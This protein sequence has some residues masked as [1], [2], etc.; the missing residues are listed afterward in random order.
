LPPSRY[1]RDMRPSHLLTTLY[2]TLS[3]ALFLSS[4]QNLHAQPIAFPDVTING[5]KHPFVIVE[6]LKDQI[7]YTINSHTTTTDFERLPPELQGLIKPKLQVE[8]EEE[9]EE[10]EEAGYN[11]NKNMPQLNKEQLAT[12]AQQHLTQTIK[13][14]LTSPESYSSIS[15]SHYSLNGDVYLKHK[16]RA[17]SPTTGKKRSY[18]VEAKLDSRGN[19]KY[20]NWKNQQL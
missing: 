16:F 13:Q 3:A 14:L 6:I 19:I 8:Q 7:K 12:L 4:T 15:S 20:I 11:S 2:V 18:E 10:E 9:Q 1:D 17:L 5:Q